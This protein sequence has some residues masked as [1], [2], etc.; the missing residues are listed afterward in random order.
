M[1]SSLDLRNLLPNRYRDKTIDTLLLNLFNRQLTQTDTVPLFGYVGDQLNLLPG[2]VQITEENLERQINQLTPFIYAQHAS[3]NLMYSWYDI[4]QKLVTLGIDYSALQHWFKSVSYNFAPPIDL[5]KFCNFQDYFWIGKWIVNYP[6]VNYSTLN[7]PSPSNY[8]VPAFANWGNAVIAPE[9]YVIARGALSGQTPISPQP[10]FPLNKWSD[11]S[12]TNLWVHRD[13]AL[14]FMQSNGIIFNSAEIVQATRPIIEYSQ[15]VG[16]NVAQDVNGKPIYSPTGT[17]P[18]KTFKNQLPLFDLY[19]YDGTH[20][21]ITSA[22]FYYLEDQEA[23][24]DPIIGRRVVVDSN[25]DYVFAHSF[26]NQANSSLYFY[27]LYDPINLPTFQTIWRKGPITTLQYS[28]LDTSGTLINQDMFTNYA[29]YYW[30]GAD[31]P[32]NPSYNPTGIPEYYV[33]EK[34]ITSSSDWSTYNYWVH[35]STLKRSEIALYSQAT[36][37]IIEFNYSLESQLTSVKTLFGQLP[38]FKQYLWDLDDNKYQLIPYVNDKTVN[39]AY[40]TGHLFASLSDLDPQVQLAIT[41]NTTI[42]SNNTFQ[43]NGVTYVQGLYNGAYYNA[44]V[45]GNVYGFKARNV[46]FTGTS[47]GTLTIASVGTCDPELI[48]FTFNGVNFDINGSVIGWYPQVNINDIVTIN[49]VTLHINSGEISF[50][51]GDRFMIEITSYVF[52][53]RNMFVNIAGTYR[54][55]TTPSQIISEVQNSVLVPSNPANSDGAWLPSPQLEWNCINETRTQIGEGDLYYHFTTIIAAQPNLIGSATGDN[56]WRNLTVKNVGLGGTIKQFDGDTAL[57]IS[58]LLQQG[59]STTALISFAETSYQALSTSI[60]QFVTD[61]IPDMLVKGQFAPPESG[62]SIDL[63]VVEAF[64]TYFSA[65]NAVVIASPSTVDDVVSAPFYDTTSSL[66]NLIVTLPYIGLGP[67][68][69]PK[70]ILDPDLN[71]NMLVHHDG[72]ETQLTSDLSNI[73]KKIVQKLYV[74]SSG[75]ETPGIISGFDF[76]GFQ[77]GSIMPYAG[78]F[79]FK[80]TTSQLFMFNAVVDNAK[81]SGETLIIFGTAFI[82]GSFIIGKKYQIESIGSTD[83]TLIGASSNVPGVIFTANGVG[84]GTGIATFAGTYIVNN[85]IGQKYGSYAYNRATND[86]FQNNGTWVGD[87]TWAYLGNNESV[88]TLPWMEIKLDLISQN[89]ELEIETELYNKCPT[90]T[91]RLDSVALQADSHYNNFMALEYQNFG[92]AHGVADIGTYGDLTNTIYVFWTKTLDYLYS[93]Q[94]AYFKIDPLTY[95]RETWGTK[96]FTTGDYTF[97]PQIGRKEGPIDFALHSSQLTELAQPGWVVATSTNN[98]AQ[99]FTYVYTFTCVS[100][101]DSIFALVISNNV[102]S[103]TVAALQGWPVPPTADNPMFFTVSGVNTFIYSDLFINVSITASL[104]GFFWGDSF[105]IAMDTNGNCVTTIVPQ[106]Y[107]KA[108]GFNQI[109]VQYGR[110]YGADVTISVNSTILNDW[111][112]KLGYRFGA[113]INTDTLTIDVQDTAIASSAYNIYVKENDFY[114]SS[115]INALRVQLVQRGSTTYQNGLNIPAIGPGGTPGEDWIFRVDNFNKNRTNLSWYTYDTVAGPYNNFIALDGS[116]TKFPWKR[117]TTTTTLRNWGTPFLVTGIQNFVN[118]IEGYSD[119][120]TSDGWSFSDP[121]NP[122]PD[123]TGNSG[124]VG[125]QLL[126]EQFIDQQF[127][128]VIAGSSFVFNP[129]YRKVWYSTPHGVVSNVKNVLGFETETTCAI[130]DQAGKQVD[131]GTIRVFR[132]DAI[133]ELVFDIPVYTLHLLTSEYEHVV[134]FEDYST[135]TLLIY[136]QFLGQRSSRIFLEGQKQANFSGKL[137]FGGHFLLGDE[138]KKNIEN[139]IDGILGLYD[140]SAI[141][142]DANSLSMARGLLGYQKK[143]YFTARGSTDATQFRFWQGMIGNKGTNFSVEAYINSA[144]FKDAQLQEYWAYKIAEYGDSRAIVKTEMIVQPDDCTGEYANYIFLEADDVVTS[145]TDI[146]NFYN[147]IPYDYSGYSSSAVVDTTSLTAILPGDETRWY[148]YSDINQL[149]YLEAAKIGPLL[150]NGYLPTSIVVGDAF[151]IR[152]TSGKPVHADCFEILNSNSTSASAQVFR[153]SGDYIVGTNPAQFT[154]PQFSR[155][156][157]STILILDLGGTPT[158]AIALIAG[159]QYTIVTIGNTDFTSVGAASNTVGVTFIATDVAIGT[160]TTIT[161]PVT[162]TLQVVAYGPAAHQYSPNLL[163]NYVDNVLVNNSIIWWDP[164]RGIH[165]PQAAASISYDTTTNPALYTDS[166]CQYMNVNTQ[167]FKP[168]GSKQVGKIW[169]NTKNLSWQP[170]SDDREFPIVFDRLARWGSL[171]DESAINVYEWV[172]SST[173]PTAAATGQSMNGEPAIANYVQRNRTWWQRPVAWRYSSNP[174]IV[175]RMFLVSSPDELQITSTVGS[176]GL[177]VLKT[178]GFDNLGITV[179]T[180]ISGGNYSV[181]AKPDAS[182]TSIFGVATVTST[183]FMVVGS[184]AGYADGAFLP[185]NSYISNLVV[186]VDSNVLRFRTAYLGQYALSYSGTGNNLIMTYLPT[187][188]NQQILITNSALT[189]VSYN[190]DVFGLILTC[191]LTNSPTTA[192]NIITSLTSSEICVRSASNIDIP[193]VFSVDGINPPLTTFSSVYDPLSFIGWI[194]WNDPTTNPNQGVAPPLNQYTPIAGNWT[195]VGNYLHDVADDIVSKTAD[196]WS[197]FDGNDYTPYKSSWTSWAVMDSTIIAACYE[198]KPGDSVYSA[199]ADYASFTTLLTFVN[200]SLLTIENQCNI[201]INGKRLSSSQWTVTMSGSSA[202]IN[203]QENLLKKGDVI[204]AVLKHYTPTLADLAFDP[205][206]SDTNPFLLVQYALDYPYVTE[207]L[208]DSN[209]NLTIYNYYYW[210]KNKTTIGAPNQLSTTS[211]TQLLTDN[212]S[213]YAIPQKI[214]FYNQLDNRPNR[215]SMISIKGLGNE[216][217]AV[218]SFKLSF[219]KD[220]S[221]R[222]RDENISLKPTF[223]EWKL[224]RQGQQDLIPIAL[225]NTLTDTL[226]GST[227]LNIPLPFTALALYDQKNGTDVSYGVDNGQIMDKPSFAIATVKYTINNTQVNK[228]VNGTKAPDY[229]T[230]TPSSASPMYA[231]TGSFDISKLNVYLSTSTNIRQFMSDLWRY[232]KPTQV[233]EI[234]FAVLQDMAANDLEID[235]FFKTSFISLSNVKTITSTT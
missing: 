26:V 73:A 9:Y 90:L 111:S 204:R 118:F 6:T 143:P 157:E 200:V 147:Y 211:V 50:A 36:K 81:V 122:I 197:W 76:P 1:A 95:V 55:V 57:L 177:A 172:Q 185:I 13:D 186:T 220:P 189:I 64:K 58:T 218:D 14:A 176:A 114:D 24:V 121:N 235:A 217:R 33:I 22:T 150:N 62:D 47:D 35:V 15:Y 164:A 68:V 231:A 132:Q 18:S 89:L 63:A 142:V 193:I 93:Q 234:F 167:K 43:H 166:I 54:T 108:E 168:W 91:H 203:I 107:F 212:T 207:I 233:N 194:S 75:Q 87:D 101:E 79:W 12:Y 102:A 198:L 228:Y 38:T 42:L 46:G 119:K 104:R 29:N 30:I 156:N 181:G 162:G 71:L 178:K 223:T 31:N 59:L 70:K 28:K 165:H 66:F 232:A 170:Y 216:V 141:D 19:Y 23:V 2:E 7:I 209:D 208:R 83:Y 169:W 148:S 80:T 155:L 106:E 51:I 98:L 105:S 103:G 135:N 161:T 137:D 125:F 215:Y 196:P 182:L 88:A 96:H 44:D 175:P 222:D 61:V 115:W 85:L 191:T 140:T 56:S 41:T 205:S 202:S 69:Q 144:S 227:Q 229:I 3:E 5:D 151:I 53:Q 78:Q 138:M 214:K 21:R 48:T 120:M 187:G 34:S 192:L 124:K 171:S 8:I 20:A 123:N 130:L 131:N 183:S 146:S 32:I 10:T 158:D 65:Q 74:R 213:I 86:T 145:T 77:P 126:I 159:I 94:R 199:N 188:E 25:G 160:G 100:R 136:D 184:L 139:S 221:L 174:E 39:D 154:Y 99:T 195:Q 149:S 230:Y 67:R 84:S 173:P 110:I 152:D 134:L 45:S 206:V 17:L 92:I 11:W 117:Y 4:V 49:G 201:Y 180:K 133:T 60:N 225:W 52:E 128:G 190:F 210:A 129:F 163:Y 97:S 112:V 37:P 109:F 113:M 153:E 27:R 82:A 226:C 40:L 219:N 127:S 16:L 179:G 224:L 116:K 72:H